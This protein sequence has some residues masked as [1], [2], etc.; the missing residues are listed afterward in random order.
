MR[1]EPCPTAA[2]GLVP[3]ADA[4][5]VVVPPLPRTVLMVVMVVGKGGGGADALHGRGKRRERETEGDDERS[6]DGA[7][8]EYV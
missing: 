3:A 8:I 6:H 1:A 7:Q 2:N 4:H 5:A